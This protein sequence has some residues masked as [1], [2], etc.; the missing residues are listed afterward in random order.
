MT[1]SSGPDDAYTKPFWD[2][3]RD[4]TLVAQQCASCAEFRWPPSRLCTFCQSPDYSW[5]EVGHV[6]RLV[7]YAVYHR[8][9]GASTTV[10][11]PPYAVALVEL[12]HGL[13]MYAPL[14]SDASP[15]DIGRQV[16]AVFPEQTAERRL[17][18]WRLLPP[19]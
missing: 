17:V 15:D 6:G 13:Q 4:C 1:V 2:A 14:V 16:V 19:Q 8:A 18:Q 10:F 7:T 12:D 3:L 11:E 5:K 9:L